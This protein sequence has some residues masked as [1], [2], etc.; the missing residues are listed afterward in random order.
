MLF[1]V[2]FPVAFFILVTGFANTFFQP[3]KLPVQE[4]QLAIQTV[5]FTQT[6]VQPAFLLTPHGS[7]SAFFLLLAYSRYMLFVRQRL[8]TIL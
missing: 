4:Q 8:I 7:Y 2:L 1:F 3:A 5:M 6:T